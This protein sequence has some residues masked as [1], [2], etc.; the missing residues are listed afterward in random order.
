MTNACA[1]PNF[2]VRH[3]CFRIRTKSREGYY[4][5]H[6]GPFPTSLRTVEQGEKYVIFYLY[7]IRTRGPRSYC[8]R[9]G[10]TNPRICEYRLKNVHTTTNAIRF[11]L[12]G[13]RNEH[14]NYDEDAARL[15]AE[16][17]YN[18]GK[19]IKWGTD[20]ESEFI[21]TV[22]SKSHNHLRHVFSTYERLTSKDIE[23]SIKS[24]FSGD[25]RVGLSSV[26]TQRSLIIEIFVYEVVRCVTINRV[27]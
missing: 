17:L 20:D 15:D 22:V 3:I 27:C 25:I 10:R 11:S 5:R 24:E 18:A 13:N 9:V 21:H 26:G 19:M 8:I 14:P 7:I 16:A 4:W 6:V 2:V 23:E 12:Q 1:A